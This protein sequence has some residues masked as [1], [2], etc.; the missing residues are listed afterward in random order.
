[1]ADAEEDDPL[2][3]SLDTPPHSQ[4]IILIA[5]GVG[6]L[7]AVAAICFLTLLLV[8]LRATLAVLIFKWGILTT[9]LAAL[10]IIAITLHYGKIPTKTFRN[11]YTRS[12][13]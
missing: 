9:S 3:G 6:G 1:M 8:F 13:H 2:Y 10:V 4:L 7:V 12:C 11:M 5:R